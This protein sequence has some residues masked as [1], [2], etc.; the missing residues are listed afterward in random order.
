MKEVNECISDTGR[1]NSTIFTTIDLTS[2]FWQMPIDDKDS[3]LTAFTVQGHGQFEWV[4]SPMGLLGCPVSFQQLMEKVLDGI[5]N[6]IVYINDVIIHVATH[7]HHLQVLDQVLAKLDQYQLKIN[8]AKCFIGNTKV[9]YLV[10]VLTPAGIRPGRE[11]LQ[12]LRDMQPSTKLRQVRQF[13][14]LCSFF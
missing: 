6:I 13:N 12:L 10:F 11:K 9:A 1:A 8:L 7:E 14:G 3:H 4:T 2:G 5:C